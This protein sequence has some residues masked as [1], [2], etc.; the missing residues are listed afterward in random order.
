MLTG[1]VSSS[2]VYS[3]L[4]ETEAGSIYNTWTVI[5]F[6]ALIL[7]A[8]VMLMWWKKIAA[9]TAP[10][11]KKGKGR[12]V[13]NPANTKQVRN[14][15][16]TIIAVAFAARL[17]LSIADLGY[18][19]D[20]GCFSSWSQVAADG[21]FDTYNRLGASIDYPPG[22]V[23][24]LYAC[25]MLGKL[26][27]CYN[28]GLYTLIVKLPAM[29]C[30]CFIAW[31]I[32]LFA[33]EKISKELTL[34]FVVFWLA[35]PAAIIDS[36]VWG[37]VD[38]VLS[39]AV[40]AGFYLVTKE[41][42]VLSSVVFGGAIM[43]KPQAIIVL[44]ILFYALLKN[45][46]VKTFIFSFLAGIGTALAVA[47]PFAVNVDMSTTHMQETVTPF[48]EMAGVNGGGFLTKL[49]TPF[50]WIVSLFMGTADHYSYATV[51]ALNFYFMTG[52]NWVKDSEPFMGLTYYT[53]GMLAIVLSAVFIWVM[54]LK[55]KKAEHMPFLAGG[56]LLLLVANFG[57]RMHERYFF[58]SIVLLL[59]AAILANTKGTAIMAIAATVLGYLTVLE[60][61]ID[62]NLGIP[63][64]WPE[65]TTYR[66]ILSLGNVLLSLA[67]AAYLAVEAFGDIK[68]T[69]FG[70]RI[71]KS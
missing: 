62:L 18:A 58:P 70:K 2:A 69:W 53:W 52:A 20:I 49:A 36:T 25:G 29:L 54:Y 23:Y 28:T 64:M 35:N 63:Y 46:K 27:N 1:T 13:V 31:F 44:P 51:N 56:T 38:S 32:Y 33:R 41:K 10:T 59:F 19:N 39:L 5:G 55:A 42:F 67:A 3:D 37:Q 11:I 21:L 50:A 34:F 8:A 24:I 14:T 40:I 68:K 47:L 26:F 15:V 71:W 61:L 17:C 60:I 48:L 4:S 16:I 22:Y 57:P 6:A 12:A 65:V 43:L 9:Q 66:F 45:K 30:D 7:F